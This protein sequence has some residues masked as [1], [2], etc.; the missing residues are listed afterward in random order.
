MHEIFKCLG[1]IALTSAYVVEN[2]DGTLETWNCTAKSGSQGVIE[3][4]PAEA[5]VERVH[6]NL[7]TRHPLR[8]A[9][10][11]GPISAEC[12]AGLTW[13]QKK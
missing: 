4:T 12:Q 3:V 6:V 11:P 5:V 2:P 7:K 10:A 1:E 8:V 13:L 9:F